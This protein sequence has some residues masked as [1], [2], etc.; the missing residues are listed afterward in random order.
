MIA[1]KKVAEMTRLFIYRESFPF[2]PGLRA[3]LRSRIYFEFNF[4]VQGIDHYFSAQY[5][6]EQIEVYR[7]VKIISCPFKNGIWFNP[8][9]DVEIAVRAS[10]CTGCAMVPEPDHLT[11]FNTRRN[12]DAD[13]FLIHSECLR[14][15]FCCIAQ[16]KS[17]FRLVILATKFRTAAAGTKHLFKKI[18]IFTFTEFSKSTFRLTA[19]TASRVT[20]GLGSFLIL[21]SIFPIFSVLI[22]FFS[23]FRI[24]QYFIGFIDLLEFFMRVLVVGVEVR[25]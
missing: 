24:T 11:I 23:F 22:V 8:E 1:N 14:M 9:C 18:R 15:C 10:I 25:M 6:C 21:L 2:Q 17:Q 20:C 5:R 16:G 12:G 19:P 3:I 4:S 13:V 7:N